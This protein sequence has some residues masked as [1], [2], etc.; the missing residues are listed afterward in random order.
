MIKFGIVITTYQRPD[1]YTPAFLTRCLQSIQN[2]TYTNFKVFLIGDKYNDNDEFVSL[3]SNITDANKI[4]F[5]NLPYAAERDIYYPDNL[6]A[7][8]KYGGCNASNHGIDV[9]LKH[10]YDY[11]CRLDHDDAWSPDHLMNFAECIETHD[12]KVICSLST[13]PFNFQ[14]QLPIVPFST[15]KFIKHIPKPGNV[16]KS[17]TCINQ[18]EILLRTRNIF[19]ESNISI[20]PGDADFWDRLGVYIKQNNISSYLV[21]RLTC[22]HD[23]EGYT[24]QL[25]YE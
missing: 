1:G 10:G 23:Y 6:D 5:E 4:Y 15:D 24:K 21:N 22:A 13:Y 11:I 2:Q 19:K 18:K 17:S 25:K 16:I 12:A 3:T 9:A 20:E 8:W 14:K 7:L